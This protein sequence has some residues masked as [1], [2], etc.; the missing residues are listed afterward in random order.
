MSYGLF[1][2]KV[3]LFS[4]IRRGIEFTMS[5]FRISVTA[6]VFKKRTKTKC[7]SI[8]FVL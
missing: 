4:K 8:F 2:D 1:R 3:K 5:L 6:S 7:E